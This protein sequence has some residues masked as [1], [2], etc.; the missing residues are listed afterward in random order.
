VTV[1]DGQGQTATASY[2]HNVGTATHTLQITTPPQ[3]NP[4]PAPFGAGVALSVTAVDSLAHTLSYL[5]QATCAEVSGTGTFS[6]NASAPAPT[7]MPPVS[8]GINNLTCL[9][10]VTVV[11]TVGASTTASFVQRVSTS[12]VVHTLAITSGPTGTPNPVTGGGTATLGVSAADS[13]GHTLTYAWTSNCP[14]LASHGTF[15]PSPSVP[16]PTWTAPP[17]LTG[18]AQACSIQVVVT[19]GQDKTANAS[20]TQNVD[21]T[22]HTLSITTGPTGTP[23]PVASAGVV[24]LSATATD[25]YAHPISHLW[26][27][28]CGGSGGHGAF[29]PNATAA[30]PT[31]TAPVNASGSEIQCVIQLT[32][33]DGQGSTDTRSYTHRVSSGVGAHSVTITAGPSGTPNPV[34]PGGSVT[35]GVTAVDSLGHALTFAWTAACPLVLGQNGSFAPSASAPAPTWTAP[36]NSTGSTQRCTIGVTVSDGQGQSASRS[37]QQTVN[38]VA[39]THTLSITTPPTGLPNPSAPLAPVALSVAAVDSLD[40][41]LTYFWQAGCA[42]VPGGGSFAP[43]STSRTPTWTP[44]PN[45]GSNDLTCLIRV[46]VIDGLGKSA[47]ASF[48]QRV[49]GSATP[50]HTL[51]ITSSPNGTPNPVTSA[52]TVVLDVTA[53]D[54]QAHAVSYAWS[55]TCPALATPGVFTPGPN[56]PAP[57]WTAPANTTGAEQTC[58]LSVTASDSFGQAVSASYPQRVSAVPHT[59][60]ISSGP[61]GS[62]NPA[63]AG[64]PV[65]LSVTAVDS[66]GHALSYLWQATCAGLDSAG[67][68][69]P[70]PSVPA[71]TWTAPVHPSSDPFSCVLTVTV[72]DTESKTAQASYTQAVGSGTAPADTVTITSGPTGT[73]N[74]VAS[75]GAATLAVAATD[76]LGHS[77]SY[78]WSATCPAAL[79]GHGAFAPSATAAAPTW[80]AP[81]NS[82]GSTQTCSIQVT[83]SDGQGQTAVANYTQN[84]NPVG[85]THT[86]SITSA[87]TGTPNPVISSGAVSLTVA[88]VDSLGHSLTYLWQSSCAGL[89]TGGTFAPNANVPTPTWTAPANPTGALL[90]CL[91]QVAVVDNFGKS[92]SASHSQQVEPAP[93][94]LTIIVPPAASPTPV[95][96]AGVL[97]LSVTAVDSWNHTLSYLWT[98]AC[99]QLPDPGAFQPTATARTPTWR[100]PANFTGAVQNCTLEVVVSDG[101]GQSQTA[102][103]VQS[104]DAGLVPFT[105]ITRN[106]VGDPIDPLLVAPDSNLDPPNYAV[107]LYEAD[108]VTEL[109]AIDA[110][111]LTNGREW[112]VETELAVGTQAVLKV[113]RTTASGFAPTWE[114]GVELPPWNLDETKEQVA[115]LPITVQGQVIYTI[116]VFADADG[117]GMDDAWE[118]QVGLNPADAGDRDTDLDGD[119]LSNFREFEIGTDPFDPDSD[120]DGVDDGAEDTGGEEPPGDGEPGD[121]DGEPGGGNPT[122]PGDWTPPSLRATVGDGVVYVSWNGV[123]VVDSAKLRIERVVP[124]LPDP[125]TYVNI[126][127]IDLDPKADRY[128]L[129][130]SPDEGALTNGVSYRLSLVL[131][132]GEVTREPLATEYLTVRPDALGSDVLPQYPTVFL[133]GFGGNGDASGTFADTF[134]FVRNTMGWSF[135][136]RLCFPGTGL[137]LRVD[138]SH[139]G[140]TSR[141]ASNAVLGPYGN[142]NCSA[143]DP[144]TSPDVDGDFFTVD[145]GNNFADYGTDAPIGG[146]L[147]H[148]AAEVEAALLKLEDEGITPVALVGH[149]TGGLAA[150]QYLVETQNE[151]NR[152]AELVT[153]GSPHRGADT[154]FWCAA[155]ANPAVTSLGGVFGR[156]VAALSIS[157]ACTSPTAVG[158]VRDTQFTC[159]SGQPQLSAFL[160]STVSLPPSV[161]TYTSVVSHWEAVEWNASALPNQGQRTADCLPAAWDGLVPSTSADLGTTGLVEDTVRVL[162]TERFQVS[163]GNDLSSILCSLN[164]ECVVIR[165]HSPVELTVTDGTG[166][167]VSRTL[168]EIPGAAF[169]APVIGGDEIATVLLPLAAAGE[170]FLVEL[171][172]KPDAAE[173]DLFTLE[174]FVGGQRSTVTANTPVSAIVPGGY[175]VPEP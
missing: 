71:P 93:H 29:S 73:P 34:A 43:S 6:P 31:W 123:L 125:P 19:D 66:L 11:D 128:R 56:V 104:V 49:S 40:H 167:R 10:R 139:S 16:A 74:P 63:P 36:P 64:S 162:Q 102:S 48:V 150:R 14:A 3:G 82:T 39:V 158:G 165:V 160:S 105:V 106:W 98:A 97:S 12:V 22:V 24:T 173:T 67:K 23:D 126:G 65:A 143:L 59:V 145:F 132:R 76:S 69:S 119:T 137:T 54:S 83:V 161:T 26:Q 152:V 1:S 142:A 103:V 13:L 94:S 175:T 135:G 141:A 140:A 15:A 117:D 20:Y 124:A 51:T 32:V 168:A 78:S 58:T 28:T 131:A 18:S 89:A 68:F 38:S 118:T 155:A 130:A 151:N 170:T 100:A 9:I 7:W 70:G 109:S 99:P 57:S 47:T 149:G 87:P 120:D 108:G 2:T 77:L 81:A 96:S 50:P 55:A 114:S 53:V 111:S 134:H 146:G 46:T 27:A 133:H 5:W 159:V 8:P 61:A 113:W 42:E 35:L 84:V 21:P 147:F 75:G 33:D 85:G 101:Q 157:G 62:P 121:G 138:P 163:E 115:L 156:L 92:A 172:P 122:D 153:Y 45:P 154:A 30:T 148:Q 44:P 95:E 107:V 127:E 110:F 91:L 144:L 52:G 4:N 171:S 136:G 174:Y 90:T 25:S 72:N 41:A 129:T 80:T 86:M 164:P 60:T 37:F 169:I 166:R 79:G 17:N 112:A 88:A 116:V